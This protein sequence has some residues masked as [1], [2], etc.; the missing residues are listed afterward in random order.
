MIAIARFTASVRRRGLV[1]TLMLVPSRLGAVISKVWDRWY[2][3]HHGTTTSRV[4]ELENLRVVGNNRHR[5]IR[6][7]PT[8]AR[9]FLKLM[10]RVRPSTDGTFVDFGCGMGRVLMMAIDWGFQKAVGVDFS[11]ELCERARGNVRKQ[12]Q[13]D[14]ITIVCADAAH[15]AIETDQTVFY[16]F[17]PFDTGLV[18]DALDHILAS[19]TKSPRHMWIIYHNPVWRSVFDEDPAVRLDAEHRF[20]DC[21]FLV[22]R[23]GR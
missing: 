14:K 17:N 16:F 9:P 23:I 3:R 10:S 6:Y 1:P 2:D 15:Y 21:V 11:V 19:H 13:S 18:R 7:E 20:A 12:G 5:G 22:Y 4:V 8:R